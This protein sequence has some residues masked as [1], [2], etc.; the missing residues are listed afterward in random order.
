MADPDDRER[1]PIQFED[2]TDTPGIR[3]KSPLP[4]RMAQD[5]DR[6]SSGRDILVREKETAH[7]RADTE[8]EK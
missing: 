7:M 3:V 4:K 1:R 8:G 6:V 5:D 2:G